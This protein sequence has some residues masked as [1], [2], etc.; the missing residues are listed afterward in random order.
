MIKKIYFM[1]ISVYKYNFL[2]FIGIDILL[3]IILILILSPFYFDKYLF[4]NIF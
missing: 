2:F 3:D 1:V 4:I